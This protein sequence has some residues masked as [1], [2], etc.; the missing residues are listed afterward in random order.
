MPSEAHCKRKCILAIATVH[1]WEDR[2]GGTI[3]CSGDCI[4]SAAVDLAPPPT[5]SSCSSVDTVEASPSCRRV[6]GCACRATLPPRSGAP[7]SVYAAGTN[8]L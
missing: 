1:L 2:E 7:G 6:L 3:T 5:P 4:G 8:A